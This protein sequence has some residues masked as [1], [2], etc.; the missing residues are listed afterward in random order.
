MAGGLSGEGLRRTL[1]GVPTPRELQGRA[2][3]AEVL[4]LKEQH[5]QQGRKATTGL[6]NFGNCAQRFSQLSGTPRQGDRQE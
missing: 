2:R 6:R 4:L 1:Q 5:L 3:T